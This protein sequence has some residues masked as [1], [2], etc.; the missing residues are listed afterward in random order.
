MSLLDGPHTVMVQ[1]RVPMRTAGYG[2]SYA[3]NGAPV[4]V[5]CTVRML[6]TSETAVLGIEAQAVIRILARS[7]PGDARSLITWGGR[8][9]ESRGVPVVCDGSRATAHVEVTAVSV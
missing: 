1:K 9:W 7:W 4:P 5:R 6:S 8:S 3:N 2:S